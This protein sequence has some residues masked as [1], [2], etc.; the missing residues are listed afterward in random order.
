MRRPE[1]KR[2]ALAKRTIP[3]LREYNNMGKKG[4]LP[5]GPRRGSRGREGAVFDMGSERPEDVTYSDIVR[6]EYRFVRNVGTTPSQV[7]V[8]G[9]DEGKG[10]SSRKRTGAGA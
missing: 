4:E 7:G 3:R 2:V 1:G 10:V 9:V 5:E 8:K 6:K